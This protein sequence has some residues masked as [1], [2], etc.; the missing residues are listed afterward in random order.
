MEKQEYEKVKIEI[1]IFDETKD[2]I[3]ASYDVG[4]W[5]DEWDGF[6]D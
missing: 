1:I 6:F 4:D 5:D 3:T 2:V